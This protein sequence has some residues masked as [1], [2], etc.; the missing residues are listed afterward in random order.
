MSEEQT[1]EVEE[2]QEQPTKADLLQIISN[3]VNNGMMSGKQAANIRATEFGIFGSHYT[4]KKTA[5]KKRKAKRKA[6][7]QARAVTRRHGYKG[8]KSPSGRR[9]AA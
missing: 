8:Q 7:R 5:G 1:P 6:Q 3:A 2:T 9:K 4:K